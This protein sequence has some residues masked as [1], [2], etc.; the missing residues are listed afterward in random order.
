[1]ETSVTFFIQV[2][3]DYCTLIENGGSDN[4]WLFARECLV[5][6]L[7]LYRAAVLLPATEPH[8]LKFKA[9]LEYGLWNT[10]R[11]RLQKKLSRDE[12][13]MVFEPLETEQPDALVGSLSDD[14]ASIWRDVKP[15]LTI[16]SNG[17][18]PAVAEA[19][20]QWRFG[21]ETHWGH[22][23]SGAVSGLQALCFGQF[24]CVERPASA[25]P[26]Q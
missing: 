9:R 17:G 7:E 23:A 22:H 18:A 26:A 21:F 19:I 3:E 20:W 6:V 8:S 15:H 16:L 24:A 11:Q 1:L 25:G 10:T 13:W 12:Y 14:L 5:S 4:P 2:A